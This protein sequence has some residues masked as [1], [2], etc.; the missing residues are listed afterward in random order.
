[1]KCNVFPR[2]ARGKHSHNKHSA[3][4]PH[5]YCGTGARSGTPGDGINP[6][7]LRGRLAG[8]VPERG[9][10]ERNQ[11]NWSPNDNMILFS[12]NLIYLKHKETVA[13]G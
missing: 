7:V 5:I 11:I 9:K 3:R 4:M 2:R 12:Y 8:G 13:F 6:A 10:Y 1:M